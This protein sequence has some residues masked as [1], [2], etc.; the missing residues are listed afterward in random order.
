MGKTLWTGR[1]CYRLMRN[2]EAEHNNYHT[3]HLPIWVGMA[4]EYKHSSEAAT[5][6]TCAAISRNIGNSVSFSSAPGA[7]EY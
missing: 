3:Q 1:E 2:I 7:E 4:A 5:N 6:Y